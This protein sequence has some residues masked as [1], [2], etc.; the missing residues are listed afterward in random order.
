MGVTPALLGLCKSQG[1]QSWLLLLIAQK[2]VSASIQLLLKPQTK[3]IVAN[4]YVLVFP[5]SHYHYIIRVTRNIFTDSCH[6]HCILT[7]FS[8]Y[9]FFSFFPPSHLKYS[10]WRLCV[11]KQLNFQKHSIPPPSCLI[12]IACLK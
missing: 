8:A 7:C 1:T 9:I 6:C 5:D 12:S 2:S 11:H 3:A 10:M 4:N